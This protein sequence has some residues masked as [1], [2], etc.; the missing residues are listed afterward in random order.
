MPAALHPS[1]SVSRTQ[2][3]WLAL[4]LSMGA[5]VS[6]GI[7]RFAYALLLPPMRADLGWSYT[8][9]GAMN[10]VNALGY[11]LGALATPL[12]LRR[13]PPGALML[14]GAVLATLFMGLCGF[15]L[16]AAPL[17]LQRLLAGVASAFMFITGGLMAARL[18]ALDAPRSGLLLGLY[19]GGTGWGISLSALLV[20]AVLQA[21]PQPHAWTWAWWA[22]ALACGAA[23][24]L[25][26]WPV[27][28]L[29]R[30]DVVAAAAAPSTSSPASAAVVAGVAA[31]VFKVRDFAP[32]LAGYAMFG[33]GYIG[34]MTFVVALLRAQGVG[35][36]AVTLFYALLGLAVVLS[37]RIWAGLL[38][39]QRGGGALARLNALLGLAT[40][41]P[42]LT[43]AWPVALASG[44][45]FGGVFLSVVASTTALVRH[46]L[47]A[48]QWAAGISAFTIVFAAGQIVGPTV[49][50]WI[51][52]GPGGL[53]RGLVFSAAALWLGALLAARQKPIGDAE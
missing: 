16:E 4:A 9:A 3:L 12:L 8:L 19:Y 10:T 51:A 50:G 29:R 34:Y 39:R 20:P 27:R 37:S 47:P 22:L 14:V 21:A 46:N 43:S 42:A 26:V 45:L 18:G 35:G 28:V 15:F 11:L 49:V 36:G 44:L 2:L 32:A 40:V 25:L 1:P 5:A 31:R 24:A 7:T 48:S 13:G 23:T 38:D 6:L 53:A 33:V 30:M 17:L 52:D 41:L